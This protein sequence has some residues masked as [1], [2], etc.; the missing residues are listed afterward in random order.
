MMRPRAAAYY[1]CA[2]PRFP[3]RLLTAIPS[4]LEYLNL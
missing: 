4:L 3:K 1:L 2:A